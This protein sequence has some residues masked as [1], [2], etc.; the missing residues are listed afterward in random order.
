MES[1]HARRSGSSFTKSS[2][3]RMLLTVCPSFIPQHASGQ[4]AFDGTTKLYDDSLSI[5]CFATRGTVGALPTAAI[6]AAHPLHWREER[7]RPDQGSRRIA[8]SLLC[9]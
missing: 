8:E 9:C 5:S 3:A 7:E 6:G 4:G 1:S 2:L